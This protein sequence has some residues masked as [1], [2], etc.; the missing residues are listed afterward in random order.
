VPLLGRFFVDIPPLQHGF[1]PRSDNAVFVMDNEAMKQVLAEYFDF[2]LQ[3][4]FH[5]MLTTQL[6]P[7]IRHGNQKRI[8]SISTERD[9]DLVH[10]KSVAMVTSVA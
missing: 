7:E 6:S 5:Q 9:P 3:F 2:P 8:R 1:D 4:S 10:C